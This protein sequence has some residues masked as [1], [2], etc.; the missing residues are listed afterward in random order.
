MS[1]KIRGKWY[2]NSILCICVTSLIIAGCHRSYYRRQADSEARMLIEQKTYDPRWGLVD[3]TIDIDPRSRMFDPFSAD[4]P[5]L[6]P[7]DPDSYRLMECVDGKR[8]YQHWHANGD[9][10]YVENPDWLAYVPINERGELVLDE[11]AAVL[12]GL[13]H[14]VEF[15][16]QREALY[17]SALEV[18]LQRFGFDA[19]LFA[20]LGSFFR[21]NGPAR[22]G[23]NTLGIEG[24]RVT[25]RRLGVTGSTL[26]IGLANSIVWNFSGPTNQSANTLINVSLVQPLLRGAGRDRILESLTQ[27]ERNLLADVRKMERFRQGFYL[28]ITT[29]RNPGGGVGSNSL[30]PPPLAPT[31]A[32]G[33][34]G[35]LSNLQAIRIQERNVREQ[36]EVL[37]QFQAFFREERITLLQVTQIETN[38]YNAQRQLAQ[39]RLNYQNALDQYKLSLGLPP[40]LPV[41]IKDSTLSQFELI[42]DTLGE[43]QNEI[44][45][46]RKRIGV[47]LIQLN[48]QIQ[49]ARFDID[50]ETEGDQWGLTWQDEFVDSLE[51]LVPILNELGPLRERILGATVAEIREDLKKLGAVRPE[52]VKN[53]QALQQVMLDNPGDYTIEADV[54]SIDEVASEEDLTEQ[55]DVIVSKMKRDA[56]EVDT[57][58]E[59]IKSIVERGKNLSPEALYNEL[60]RKVARVAPELAIKL[61]N[62]TLELSLVQARARADAVILPE[63]DLTWQQAIAIA[64]CFRLDW[65]NARAALVDAYRRIQ[66]FANDLESQVD[67]V[68][69]GDIGNV[70]SNPMRINFDNSSFGAGMR[71]DAPITRL[72]ERNRYRDALIQY[73]RARRNY[74]QFKDAIKRNLRQTIRQVELAQIIFELARRTVRTTVRQLELARLD[75]ERPPVIQRALATG[76]GQLGDQTALNLVNSFNQLQNAQNQFL[77]TWVNFEAQRRGLDFDL[78]TMR[79]TPEGYWIDPGDIDETIALRAAEAFGIICELCDGEIDPYSSFYDTEIPGITVALE[80]ADRSSIESA[81]RD[82]HGDTNNNNGNSIRDAWEPIEGTNSPR[83][84]EELRSPRRE[85]IERPNPEEAN[86]RPTSGRSAM[87]PF[88]ELPVVR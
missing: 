61:N 85:P 16:T 50:L 37:A 55:L 75:L 19:Q 40:D 76:G 66:F 15:Q 87:L 38:L 2:V 79:M 51:K 39:L 64:K 47:A 54:L 22:G 33:F 8:G 41:I 4:H 32:G 27:A 20:G 68:F 30:A 88:R 14:S 69:E 6:P 24:G 77:S 34:L 5:P 73:Q 31:Q 80:R 11:E 48:S 74:Y 60:D 12:L 78:G 52:R 3:S 86:R 59:N 57:T 23:A 49:S 29:G 65:M 28:T 84:I 9:T 53:L 62:L 13:L 63:I 44:T 35:L 21:S 18:S 17:L 83:D 81:P 72:S 7:D 25:L 1:H 10:R 42:S 45:Q 82:N 43:N 67:L 36:E 26:V 46:I 70:G 58:I 56:D 71:F